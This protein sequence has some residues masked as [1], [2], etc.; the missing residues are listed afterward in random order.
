MNKTLKNDREIF[1]IDMNAMTNQQLEDILGYTSPA[2]TT[3]HRLRRMFDDRRVFE[4]V[5]MLMVHMVP[6]C[7]CGGPLT[8]DRSIGLGECESCRAKHRRH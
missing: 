8:A 1:S 7:S 6:R 3:E 2:E 5:V 4:T